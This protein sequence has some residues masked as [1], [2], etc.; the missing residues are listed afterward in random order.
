MHSIFS[1]SAFQ[2]LLNNMFY[3]VWLLT[4]A[5]LYAALAAEA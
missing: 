3:L 5:L 1:L 2:S 4:G